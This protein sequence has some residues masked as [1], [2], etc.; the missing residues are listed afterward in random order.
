MR[1]LQRTIHLIGRNVIE[2]FALILL[3]QAFPIKFGSLQQRQSSHHIGLCKCEWILN[4]SI[5]MTLCCQ[6]NDTIHMLFLHQLVEC[7]EIANIHL[8]KLV[9]WLILYVLEISQ[10][11]SISQ[12]IQIN[13]IILGILIYEQTNYMASNKACTTCN[14]YI[15][16]IVFFTFFKLK[17]IF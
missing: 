13:Y 15:L 2:S 6:V 16:H 14:Y 17:Y 4:T 12:L 10:I 5:H 1:H 3:R 9:I 7:I 8:H 11:T